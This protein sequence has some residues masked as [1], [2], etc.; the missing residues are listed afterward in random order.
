M[1]MSKTTRDWILESIADSIIT[2]RDFCGNEREAAFDTAYDLG[3][4]LTSKG[5]QAALSIANAN[6]LEY[7]K[8]AGVNNPIDFYERISI[9]KAI[10]KQD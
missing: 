8:L 1:S 5:Y 10:N 9:N 7:Q 3:V 6:W 4:K 2:T